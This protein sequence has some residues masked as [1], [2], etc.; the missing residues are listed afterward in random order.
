M[1]GKDRYSGRRDSPAYSV[2]QRRVDAVDDRYHQYELECI[3]NKNATTT[4]VAR[5][6]LALFLA[7]AKEYCH[8]L[9]KH[10]SA[11]KRGHAPE[12]ESRPA[13]DPFR[14]HRKH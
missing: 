2:G 11:G 3:N 9:M 1:Q 12:T 8:H 14:H 10:R 5:Q 13:N 7:V 6:Q 4:G